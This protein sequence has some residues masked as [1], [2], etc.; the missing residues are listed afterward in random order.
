MAEIR[1]GAP[2]SGWEVEVRYWHPGRAGW[3]RAS[4]V[5][6]S[7]AQVR[8][9]DNPGCP[10]LQALLPR[11]GFRVAMPLAA[12]LGRSA[13]YAAG[14]LPGRAE[15]LRVACHL[16][17]EQMLHP[18][19]GLPVGALASISGLCPRTLRAGDGRLGVFRRRGFAAGFVRGSYDVTLLGLPRSFRGA[20]L[21]LAATLREGEPPAVVN[22]R[23]FRRFLAA[24]PVA[25]TL[26]AAT[27]LG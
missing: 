20:E 7:Y 1:E 4:G 12:R 19:G 21:M 8:F 6:M 17:A 16:A 23:R 13:R 27:G 18:H 10:V 24:L 14:A 11:P 5:S 9:C 25:R 3:G 26:A 22:H 2:D 15:R